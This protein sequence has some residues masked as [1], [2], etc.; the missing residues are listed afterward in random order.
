MPT[1]EREDHTL[2]S[3]ES[4]EFTIGAEVM[5]RDGEPLGSVAYVVVQP[6]RLHVTNLV[7]STGSLLGRDIVVPVDAVEQADEQR[8]HLA[9]TKEQFAAQPDYVDVEYQQPTQDWQMGGLGYPGS[10][11]LW[12]TGTYFPQPESVTVNAPAGTV[13]LHEGMDVQ[14]GD[15]HRVGSID[16]LETDPSTGDLTAIA[17]KHGFLFTHDTVIPMEEIQGVDNDIVTLRTSHD[18][19][20]KRFHQESEAGQG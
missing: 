19:L 7:V 3:A 12:P 13:G 2:N 6:P 17:V 4:R 11:V 9:L 15:G 5:A 8:V 18:E 16:G 1:M 10:T 20:Q 14:S